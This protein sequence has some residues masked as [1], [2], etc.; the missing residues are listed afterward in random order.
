MKGKLLFVAGVA[1]G[2]VVGSRAGRQA[3]ESIKDKV[4]TA[5]TNPQVQNAVSKARD[6]AEQKAPKL[7]GVGAGAAGTAPKVNQAVAESSDGGAEQGTSGTAAA[8][9]AGTPPETAEEAAQVFLEQGDT[10]E[11]AKP[12]ATA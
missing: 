6:F 8:E 10:D 11:S 4:Q 3:Y 7:T 12:T 9:G 5:R 2:Y 1:A